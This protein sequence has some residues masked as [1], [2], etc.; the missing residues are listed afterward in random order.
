[1]R[2]P[3]QMFWLWEHPGVALRPVDTRHF[4]LMVD[5]AELIKVLCFNLISYIVN[6]IQSY[7]GI[8]YY[9][10]EVFLKL[11]GESKCISNLH[12]C[13]FCKFNA[14]KERQMGRI[15]VWTKNSLCPTNIVT[16][17]IK[18]RRIDKSNMCHFHKR[19]LSETYLFMFMTK[20][21]QFFINFCLSQPFNSR[22]NKTKT[23]ESFLRMHVFSVM[24]EGQREADQ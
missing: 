10:L 5:C 19:P 4:C 17:L 20:F 15:I 6:Q 24:C 1:M 18:L 3:L 8:L 22:N 9:F 7:T 23:C 21:Q 2:C 13:L 14:K 12:S 16:S 11:S